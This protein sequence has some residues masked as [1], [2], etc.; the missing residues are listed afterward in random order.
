M[1]RILFV[2]DEVQILESIRDNLRKQRDRWEMVFVDS[3]KAALLELAK[4]PF[5][6]VVSDMQMPVTDGATLLGQVR[7][8]YPR[9]VR[10]I[11]SGQADRDTILRA[12]PVTH[13][14]LSKP[15]EPTVLRET[16]ER[17]CALQALVDDDAIRAMLGELRAL[18]SLPRTYTELA[19]AIGRA[20][21][22]RSEIATVIERDPPLAAK[23]LQLA[24][25]AFF[26][27]PRQTS[28][29]QDAIAYLGVDLLKSL[30][31]AADV[32]SSLEHAKAGR[33]LAE[34]LQE[35]AVSVARLAKRLSPDPK[36]ADLAFTAGLLHNLGMMLLALKVPERAKRIISVAAE[37]GKPWHV[38]EIEEG[39][40]GHAAL[41]AY[42]LGA[43]GL[44]LELVEAVAYQHCPSSAPQR[45]P[46]ELLATI[47]V[48]TTLVESLCAGDR[49]PLARVDR[50]LAA[51]A[52]ILE[53][54]PY[55]LSI[56]R[57]DALWTRGAC[58]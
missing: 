1:K 8:R 33:G 51:R 2:D 15:C 7:E 46:L 20:G 10:L 3:A 27:T 57:D 25:S 45:C 49:D 43:W 42:L 18:P 12:I 38:V 50:A 24:N 11:L 21:V 29:V 14:F 44:P 31:L 5:D 23:V 54:L 55:Y 53:K 17:V 34:T 28:T 52:G 19:N 9:T 56:A 26:G 36:L 32:F 6:I 58:A 13:Q 4:G 40:P 41:G 48:A 16:L 39:G 30:S 37:T 35:R 47:H 22:S